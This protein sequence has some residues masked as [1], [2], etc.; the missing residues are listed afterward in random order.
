[1][2]RLLLCTALLAFFP[3]L[4]V[5]ASHLQPGDAVLISLTQICG[6]IA[7]PP[8]AYNRLSVIP[9]DSVVSNYD[10][11]WPG[12]ALRQIAYSDRVGMMISSNQSGESILF[13]LHDDGSISTFGSGAPVTGGFISG[14]APTS[15]DVFLLALAPATWSGPAEMELWRMTPDGALAARI[16]LPTRAASSFD[17]AADQC[18]VFYTTSTAIARF[19]ACQGT[20][21][22]LF[23]D[24][25]STF[26][27]FPVHNVRIAPGQEV[28]VIDSQNQLLRFSADGQPSGTVAIPLIAERNEAI[29]AFT[30][31]ET[32]GN[33]LVA[34]S[35]PCR[36][37]PDSGGRIFSVDR[38]SGR[39]LSVISPETASQDNI[40]EALAA[41]SEWRAAMP[42]TPR[43]RA[44]GH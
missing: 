28:F 41:V 27:N 19:D 3:T 5:S 35:F 6:G 4:S 2:P 20:A 23:A 30:F 43:R 17:I 40:F 26:A 44:A 31:D 9:R 7:T 33:L 11:P 24:F 13:V 34:T 38:S 29:S 37:Y 32:A 8:P 36:Q 21:L 1:M 22:P 12:Y 10:F 39:V 14:I 18:T 15:T 42:H 25:A 16:P